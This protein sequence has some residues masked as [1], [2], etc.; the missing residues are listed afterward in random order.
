MTLTTAPFTS[1]QRRSPR[2]A[3]AA[4][5]LV[6]IGIAS[7]GCD[8]A[9][10][11]KWFGDAGFAPADG[12][13]PIGP[14]AGPQPP[15]PPPPAGTTL[16]KF[17][18]PLATAS[19][20]DIELE[21]QVGSVSFKALTGQCAP[22]TGSPCKAIPTGSQPVKLLR[23]GKVLW[24][25]TEQI[26]PGQYLFT[27]AAVDDAGKPKVKEPQTLESAAACTA[28]GYKETGPGPMPPPPPP[29]PTGNA[30]A[31]FCHNLV[32]QND[33]PLTL[34]LMVGGVKLTARSG[35][36]STPAGA[37]CTAI[38][39][40]ASNAQLLLNGRVA[41]QGSLTVTAGG[42]LFIARAPG[43]MATVE[44][45][46]IPAASCPNA[47]QEG[48]TGPMPPPPPPPPGGQAQVK[49]CNNLPAELP[50]T[51]KLEIGTTVLTAAPGRCAPAPG[52]ACLGVPAG[53]PMAK[54]SADNIVLGQ[55]PL[56]LAANEELIILVK[57]DAAMK[58]PTFVMGPPEGTCA[59]FPN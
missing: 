12:G 47:A 24:E 5:A 55:G 36:C 18:N 42:N 49:L 1:P 8:P 52:M 38:S 27:E 44:T 11:S 7:T 16:L 35:G 51:A 40:G 56:E 46:S 13:T 22:A 3:V 58:K 45:D 10:A 29:P 9:T 33:A 41:W 59:A 6:G 53:K 57:W 37:A 20:A 54:I 25:V 2:T 19:G 50:L 21:L 15:P 32:D 34:D 28:A 14:D 39:A 48:T 30:T 4:L 23:D 31:K 17:C 43:G 26:D